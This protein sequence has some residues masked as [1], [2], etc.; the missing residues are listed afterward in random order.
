M[1][2]MHLKLVIRK[3]I[4]MKTI[5]KT[6]LALMC[7]IFLLTACAAGEKVSDKTDAP[8]LQKIT[9][10]LDWTPNTNHTGIYAAKSLGYYKEAGI[11]LEILT[12][13]KDGAMPLLGAGKVDFSITV[14]EQLAMA[15]TNKNPLPVTAVAG[16]LQH[17]TSGIISL[18]DKGITSFKQLEGKKYATWDEPIEKA[19]LKTC[20]EKQGGDFSKVKMISVTVENIIASLQSNQVD[21]VW[22]FQGWDG[23]A[24]KVKGLDT[25]YFEFRDVDPVFDYYTPVLAAN[26]NFLANN[27]D[28]TK[29]FLAA[30]S[31]GYDYAIANPK[32]AGE[33]LLKEVPGLDKNIILSS[34]DYLAGQYKADAPKWGEIDKDRWQNFFDWLAENKFIPRK[35]EPNEGYTNAYLPE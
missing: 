11:D 22:I 6:V 8:P 29:K 33:I 16:I 9:L 3:V 25:N 32:A 26:N 34:Q 13:P 20:V 28:I 2:D 21:A 23:I 5:L 15:L 1:P 27:Q 35:I 24:C 31:K 17:N 30:T 7:A 19:T 4:K 14:Q 10:M 12:P 18:K